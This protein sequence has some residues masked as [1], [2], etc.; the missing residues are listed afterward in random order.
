MMWD[1]VSQDTRAWL[2]HGLWLT[3]ELGEAQDPLGAG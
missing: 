3:F 2:M 1:R